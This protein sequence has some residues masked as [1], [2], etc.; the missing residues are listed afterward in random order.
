MADVVK[1]WRHVNAI[2]AFLLGSFPWRLIFIF[3]MLPLEALD[4]SENQMR[5]Q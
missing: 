4:W 5:S 3:A 2:E 1:S